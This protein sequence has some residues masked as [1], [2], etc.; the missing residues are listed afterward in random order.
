MEQQLAKTTSASKVQQ[1]AIEELE[2]NMAAV[3]FTFEQVPSTIFSPGPDG[4]PL[5]RY[6]GQQKFIARTV[7]MKV[8]EIAVVLAMTNLLMFMVHCKFKLLLKLTKAYLKVSF[9]AY[10]VHMDFNYWF[11]FSQVSSF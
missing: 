4:V 8:V 11:F 10:L 1:P 2:N 7:N 5:Q 6:L 3:F 9:M